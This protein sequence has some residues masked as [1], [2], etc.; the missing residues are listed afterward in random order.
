MASVNIPY[1]GGS[2]SVNIPDFAMEG[3]QVDLLE[4]ANR[5]TDAL[6]K[7]AQSMGISV[8]ND[9]Q[10]TKSN[11]DLAAQIRKGNSESASGIARLNKSI[12]SNLSPTALANSMMG[13]RSGEESLSGLM[14]KDGLLGTLGLT[15]MGAQIGS[16]FGILEE[17]GSAMGALRR[18]GGGVSAELIELKTAAA[19]VGLDMQTLAKITVEN[20]NA[21]RSLGSSTND[22][23]TNFLKLNSMLRESTRDMAFF[24]MSTKEMSS[25]LIDE[26]EL[27]RS[28]RNEAFLEAG[29]R[30]QM[31]NSMKENLK[32]NEVMASLTGQDVQDRIKARNEFRKNAIVAAAQSQMNQKQLDSQN[33]LVD[34]L[35]GLGSAGAAGG[36]IQQ[37]LT[38]LIAGVP[39]DK[40]NDSFTQLSAA[41][42]AE[43]IDLRANLEQFASMV[44]AGA[45]P[46][47]MAAASQKLINQ[48]ANI[49]VDGNILS[50]AGAG[51]EGAML[52]LTAR[53]EAFA[54]RVNEGETVQQSVNNT[55]TQFETDVA[56]GA[57][58]LSGMASQINV[59]TTTLQET[60]SKSML[61][62][63]NAD[64]SNPGGIANFIN[65]LEKLPSSQEFQAMTNL[66]TE[67]ATLASGA[68]GMTS[69]FGIGNENKGN[70]E[71]FAEQGLTIKALAE[72]LDLNLATLNSLLSSKT[73][74]GGA[75][76]VSTVL[77]AGGIAVAMAG[78]FKRND[79]KT[80]LPVVIMEYAQGLDPRLPG[81][82]P[83]GSSN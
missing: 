12:S 8:Q 69:F 71:K 72:S 31:V 36:P 74:G 42:S 65:N 20:G 52:L 49:D 4:Q 23:T 77:T 51:Q 64:P 15:M 53:Q 16:L 5:Q 50:R 68:Q 11:K 45:D 13:A 18:T 63:F 46:D 67:I 32:L 29:A 56:A 40:F 28:T 54:S 57:A 21:I 62:A 6:Q 55:M 79:P 48:F 30:D 75:P 25:M 22:G 61:L 83:P 24:G 38:N 41:A 58:A 26:I 19:A 66:V 80:Y 14:G 78:A 82:G 59:A 47:A 27:R 44:D 43:G 76:G 81:N 9:Q 33:A 1:G 70:L 7:I 37:A 39:M 60:I 17:F 34:N 73:Q 10:E 3:T 35:A 2:V